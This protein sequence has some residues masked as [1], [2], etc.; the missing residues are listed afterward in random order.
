M[1]VSL[2]EEQTSHKDF[3]RFLDNFYDFAIRVLAAEQRFGTVHTKADSSHRYVSTE[4]RTL[5]DAPD[6]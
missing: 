6:E 3:G 1:Y 5:L 2:N 4:A